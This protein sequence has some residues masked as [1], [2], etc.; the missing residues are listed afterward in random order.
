MQTSSG[1]P[2]SAAGASRCS[3]SLLCAVNHYAPTSGTSSRTMHLEC[4]IVELSPARPC[5]TGT[6]SK[7]SDTKRELVLRRTARLTHAGDLIYVNTLWHCCEAVVAVSHSGVVSRLSASD[8]SY[9][10]RACN[11]VFLFAE[12]SSLTSPP[13]LMAL[14][15][16]GA[17]EATLSGSDGT[18]SREV[19]AVQSQ[20]W[21]AVGSLL[22][23]EQNI[24]EASVKVLQGIS[25]ARMWTPVATVA[26]S[27]TVFLLPSAP[28]TTAIDAPG[29]QDGWKW[30]TK[31]FVGT[32]RRSY[33]RCWPRPQVGLFRHCNDVR[34]QGRQCR[35]ASK[36]RTG[37][38]Q[39][40][41]PLLTR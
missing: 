37:A 30:V 22:G 16:M 32:D 31:L 13:R 38:A 23:D 14:A 20:T 19:E 29:P 33:L 12:H 5:A 11:G 1:K 21:H 9:R 27:T 7:A 36:Q 24:P 18:R 26:Q 28:E 35:R 25:L 40:T 17:T 15:L 10:T 3:P 41:A 39:R 34:A 2:F 6:A 8:G 4:A